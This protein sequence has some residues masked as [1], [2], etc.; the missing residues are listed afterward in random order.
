[1][2]AS[3]RSLARISHRR[4]L[5]MRSNCQKARWLCTHSLGRPV[6]PDVASTSTGRRSRLAAISLTSRNSCNSTL[7]TASSATE[8]MACV[9]TDAAL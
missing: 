2:L 7:E 1:M 3:T 6:E 5:T 4:W 8:V 9:S